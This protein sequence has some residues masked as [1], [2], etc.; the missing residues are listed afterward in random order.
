MILFKLKMATVDT[1]DDGCCGG[2]GDYA[3]IT[4]APRLIALLAQNVQCASVP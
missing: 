3:K 1:D 4:K 2:G